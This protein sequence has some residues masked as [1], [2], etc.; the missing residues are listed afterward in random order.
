VAA[1]LAVDWLAMIYAHAILRWAGTTLQI[2]AVV[3]GV[4]QVAIGLQVMLR[5]L[6]QMGVFAL[7]GA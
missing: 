7:H 5:S 6:S 1:I 3:L 4:T 2:L